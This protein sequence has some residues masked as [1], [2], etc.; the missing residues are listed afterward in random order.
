MAFLIPRA[1]PF[2]EVFSPRWGGG[3]VVNAKVNV[4]GGYRLQAVGYEGR[5]WGW[6]PGTL[7]MRPHL[8]G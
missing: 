7:A 3:R 6:D 4:N 2:A 8:F 5:A 1:A